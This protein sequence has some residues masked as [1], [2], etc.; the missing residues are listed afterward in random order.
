MHEN[1]GGMFILR[2]D[3]AEVAG[4]ATEEAMSELVSA[5]CEVNR[6]IPGC[7]GPAIPYPVPSTVKRMSFADIR[8]RRQVKEASS[9]VR[10][11][12]AS[13][14]NSS[15]LPVEHPPENMFDAL[16]SSTEIRT[17]PERGRGIYAKERFKRSEKSICPATPYVHLYA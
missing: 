2:D 7:S 16:P 17:S 1:Y 10:S 12:S 6:L 4:R 3:V 13:K 8:A 15:S 5:E 11:S 14:Q 9:H